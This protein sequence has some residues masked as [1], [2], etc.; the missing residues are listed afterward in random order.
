MQVDYNWTDS[1]G[2]EYNIRA[3][4]HPLDRNRITIIQVETADGVDVDFHDFDDEEQMSIRWGAKG[5]A[6]ELDELDS[7][8]DDDDE[9]DDFDRSEEELDLT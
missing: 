3:E 7:D 1:G 4:V 9:D 5:A 8:E 6:A 2:E